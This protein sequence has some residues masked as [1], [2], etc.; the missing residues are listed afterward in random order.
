MTTTSTVGRKADAALDMKVLSYL[1]HYKDGLLSVSEIATEADIAPSY[2]QSIF[3]R[4]G[5]TASKDKRWNVIRE[6]RY[7]P[8]LKHLIWHGG[9]L[10]QA[11]HDI[12]LSETLAP[13]AR[14][15]A[16]SLGLNLRAYLTA[17]R[18]ASPT[19]LVMIM[20]GGGG[21]S[22]KYWVQCKS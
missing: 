5:S 11:L 17:W 4:F 15:Y 13:G 7:L 19:S 16:E 8:V 18:M 12:G 14:R 20:P 1:S 10:T 9:T 2:V 6:R 3:K 21:T 22:A